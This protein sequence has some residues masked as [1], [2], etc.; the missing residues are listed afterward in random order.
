MELAATGCSRDAAG[1]SNGLSDAD[2]ADEIAQRI[3]VRESPGLFTTF[4]LLNAAG[5]D[6]E[7]P[8]EM[9]PVRRAVRGALTR[10]VPD[11]MFTRAEAYYTAHAGKADLPEYSTVALA[12]SGPPNFTPGFAWIDD[13]SKRPPL[14]SLADLPAMLVAFHRSFPA[15]SLYRSQQLAYRAYILDYQAVV[16]R[17]AAAAVRYARVQTRSELSGFGEHSRTVVIPNL[18]MA[19]GQLFA[20]AI[21]T[22]SYIIEGPQRVVAFNPHEFIHAITHRVSYDTAR[23]GAM[24]RKATAAHAA[25]KRR[26]EMEK[27][28]SLTAFLDENLVRAIALR[29]H[30]IRDDA[31]ENEL[32]AKAVDDAR[33]GMVLVPY[34]FEQLKAYESQGDPLAAYYPKL[35]EHLD[36]AREFARWRDSI[37]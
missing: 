34:F 21:D 2:L 27:Y 8:A 16:R 11:A 24:Q 18:L 9:H 37:H 28:A 15:D 35:L 29:Y 31:R 14:R 20:L 4:A 5:Y 19:H 33:A 25:V 10:L 7:E 22:T 13:L 3:E 6:G 32:F 26:P 36:G 1:A 23:Y 17:E 30:E 12:T